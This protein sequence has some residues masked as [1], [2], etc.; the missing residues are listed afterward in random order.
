MGKIKKLIKNLIIF[1]YHATDYAMQYSTLSSVL[2]CMLICIII[3]LLCAITHLPLYLFNII[4]FHR[5]SISKI[6]P[7]HNLNLLSLKFSSNVSK[8]S[9]NNKQVDNILSKYEEFI[10]VIYENT[11]YDNKDAMSW[12]YLNEGNYIINHTSE[13][14]IDNTSTLNIKKYK[15]YVDLINNDTFNMIIISLLESVM[16]STDKCSEFTKFDY[17]LL[18]PLLFNYYTNEK[19]IFILNQNFNIVIGK[20]DQNYIYISIDNI[21]YGPQFRNTTFMVN[22]IDDAYFILNDLLHTSWRS[23]MRKYIFKK[24]YNIR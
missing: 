12:M 18:K 15:Y 23:K 13:I 4:I 2:Y 6:Y 22:S 8:Y 17:Q 7:S 1:R 9:R 20:D 14:R 21:T 5:K 10:T 3:I 11:T 19:F 24:L 16:I